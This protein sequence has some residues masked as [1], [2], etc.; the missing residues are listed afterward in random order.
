M[1]RD[2]VGALTRGLEWAT[3]WRYWWPRCPDRQPWVAFLGDAIGRGLEGQIR[4]SRVIRQGAPWEGRGFSAAE[5]EDQ[6][7]H[8]EAALAWFTRERATLMG[9]PDW[10]KLLLDA[11]EGVFAMQVRCAQELMAVKRQGY[12]LVNVHPRAPRLLDRPPADGVEDDR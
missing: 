1:R 10:A 12:A 3:W 5:W 11:L 9:V 8:A 2:G 4:M 7:A 6:T